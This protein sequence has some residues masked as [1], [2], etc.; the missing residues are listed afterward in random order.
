MGQYV[1]IGDRLQRTYGVFAN[2]PVNTSEAGSDWLPFHT[3]CDSNVGTPYA[4]DYYKLLVIYSRIFIN[5]Y[6]V[7]GGPTKDAPIIVYPMS[8]GN[9]AEGRMFIN[10][11]DWC[12]DT[13]RMQDK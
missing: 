10:N 4:G 7:A 9:N 12:K 8:H 5:F 2:L 3:E 13:L 6:A 11:H 1:G